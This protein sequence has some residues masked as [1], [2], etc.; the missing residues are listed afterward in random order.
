MHR[1]TLATLLPILALAAAA[2]FAG[3]AGQMRQDMGP[4]MTQ[5]DQC[6][7]GMGMMCMMG[8]S[9]RMMIGGQWMGQRLEQRL[10]ALKTQ[11]KITEAQMPQWNV[12]AAAVR[13]AAKAMT[14]QRQAMAGK[15][16][17][18][19]LP[20]RLDFHEATLVSHFE[21]LRTTKAAA[22]ALYAVLTADQKKIADG[23]V[24]GPTRGRMRGR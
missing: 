10:G 24:M 4:G 19:T 11:L 23:A 13:D 16:G 6:E 18:A 3:A 9:P 21:Y 15:M 1:K 14:D 8:D 5:N 20:E 2:P 7:P 12:Y 22:A 17:T